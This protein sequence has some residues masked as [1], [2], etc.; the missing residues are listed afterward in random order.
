M[1]Q[2]VSE[3]DT[4]RFPVGKCWEVLD[5][6]PSIPPNLSIPMANDLGRTTKLKPQYGG[7]HNLWTMRSEYTVTMSPCSG[8]DHSPLTSQVLCTY[9]WWSHESSAWWTI[10]PRWFTW[11]TWWFQVCLTVHAF[12]CGLSSNC[13]GIVK[14]GCASLASG[15]STLWHVL[16]KMQPKYWG[17]RHPQTSREELDARDSKDGSSSPVK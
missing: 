3:W 6:N 5:L 17:W 1:Q 10:W 16:R 11:Y 9:L 4:T 15:L 2:R 14:S 7:S 12:L 8:A 13:A